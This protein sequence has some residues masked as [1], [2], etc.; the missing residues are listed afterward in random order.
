MFQAQPTPYSGSS[1]SPFPYGIA[2]AA[3]HSLDFLFPTGGA[4]AGGASSGGCFYPPY[5]SSSPQPALHHHQQHHQQQFHQ[6]HQQLPLRQR[7]N[8]SGSPV[9]KMEDQDAGLHDMAA[10]QAA[11]ERFQPGLEVRI[12]RE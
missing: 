6:H 1:Y 11:A 8:R 12:W 5:S 4:G 2:A 3:P 7:L 10:Q 9:I